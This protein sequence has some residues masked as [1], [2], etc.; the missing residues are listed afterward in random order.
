MI[1][2]CVGDNQFTSRTIKSLS[3]SFQNDFFLS[4]SDYNDALFKWFDQNPVVVIIELDNLSLES[5]KLTREI[6]ENDSC[7]YTYII[8]ITHHALPSIDCHYYNF[9][10]D[11]LITEPITT[12]MMNLY[13]EAARRL[14]EMVRSN[15][16]L[17]ALSQVILHKN[18]DAG[19]QI[20]RVPIFSTILARQLKNNEK[21]Q[22]IISKRF[23][24]DLFIFSS[25]HDIGKVSIDDSILK[26]PGKLSDDERVLMQ[27]HAIIG[28]NILNSIIDK[29]PNLSHLKKA[30]EIAN[31]HHEH[32]DGHGYPS[33]IS[34]QE[35]P[36]MARI[37]ALA[38][39][40]DALVSERI[41]KP[42]MTHEEAK[43]IIM[44]K[45]GGQFDPDIIKAFLASELQFKN[46]VLK[47]DL[48]LSK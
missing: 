26:K 6:R 14:M 13:Y 44:E 29:F 23:I 8:G 35:I 31:F 11:N 32:F 46:I 41:Y 22:S 43:L 45:S 38:D 18:A 24:S 39:V 17:Y 36:L 12:E 27:Q 34:G 25:I 1:T 15:S 10:L 19:K 48:F 4:A 30:A 47:N 7:E 20:D 21:Y 3:I 33:G 9:G 2:L 5:E 42:T 37:V 28:A 40:Y 16:L